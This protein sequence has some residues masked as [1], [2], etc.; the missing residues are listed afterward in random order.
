MISDVDVDHKMQLREGVAN[1]SVLRG[2]LTQI[3]QK[4]TNQTLFWSIGPLAYSSMR[5]IKLPSIHVR[6][7]QNQSHPIMHDQLHTQQLHNNPNNPPF[8]VILPIDQQR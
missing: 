1:L 5:R 4:F 8:S 2:A 7:L 6:T 3:Q